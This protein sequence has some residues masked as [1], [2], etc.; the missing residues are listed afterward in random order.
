MRRFEDNE[1]IG[2]DYYHTITFFDFRYDAKI[3]NTV[4][5]IVKPYHK[6]VMSA[7]HR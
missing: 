2:Y 7:L 3:E 4:S 6:L 1:L 5:K